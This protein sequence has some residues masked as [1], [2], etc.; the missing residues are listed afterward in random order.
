MPSIDERSRR[1]SG[2]ID[3]L[4]VVLGDGQEWTFPLPRLRLTPQRDGDR[5]KVRVGRAGLAN[6]ERWVEVLTG[7]LPL[8]P[9]AMWDLR[10]D[11]AATLLSLNYEL[12]ESEL[13][14]LL[15]WEAG[16]PASEERWAQIDR[17]ILGLR[18]KASSAT[19]SSG[20]R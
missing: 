15:V 2:F 10:M 7:S 4:P 5:Y 16:D 8:P 9:E 11:A 18:P 20:A 13:E 12:D 1:K 6:Y 19:S 14:E 17:A 3:G